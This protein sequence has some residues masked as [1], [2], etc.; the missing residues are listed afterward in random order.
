MNEAEIRERLRQA[1]GDGRYPAALSSRVEA[2]LKH[3]TLNQ[4]LRTSPGRSHSPWLVSLG[5]AGSL[6]GALLLVLLM[7]S[8]VLG[9]HMW[10]MN[11]R[12]VVP[13]GRVGQ[14]PTVKSYQSMLGVDLQRFEDTPNYTCYSLGDPNCVPEDAL[15]TAAMQQWL[16]DLDRSHPPARFAALDGL[17]RRD[18]A[19]AISALNAS[20]TAYQAKD[21]KGSIAASD[22]A[23][24]SMGVFTSVA[25]EIIASSQ[26]TLVQYTAEV[27]LDRAYMLACALCQRLVSANQVSCPT[28]QTPSCV[29][30]IAAVRLQ[31]EAFLEHLVRVYAPDALAAKDAH[32]QVDL[33]TADRELD[34]M[35]AALSAGDQVALQTGH[36]ALRRALNRVESDVADIAG[37]N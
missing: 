21:G 29:D 18:L 15:T 17:M 35:G 13:G 37:S 4:H 30:E 25:R 31:V 12:P 24:V 14:D 32:L 20:D 9:V 19:L 16:D 2:R 27:R 33:V 28:G 8:L 26:G 1:V 5:R 6:V 3:P 10:L 34:A 36:D 23:G 22:A 7:A 11:T